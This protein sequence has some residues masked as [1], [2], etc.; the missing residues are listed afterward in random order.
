ME[1]IASS[2]AH[3]VGQGGP[4]TRRI[5]AW[6]AYYLGANPVGAFFT[7][8]AGLGK[9]A[10]MRADAAAATLAIRARAEREGAFPHA[11]EFY[12]SAGELR[13]AGEAW[14][15]F[16]GH[17]MGP[18]SSFIYLDE[19]HE[20]F[21]GSTV[22][23]GKIVSLIKG[24]SDP[25]RGTIREVSFGDEGAVIRHASTVAFVCG[26]NFP[27]KLK[28]AEAI[29]SRLG[30]IELEQYSDE[31][32][33][34]IAAII[35][36]AAGLR[37]DDGTLST[38]AR[39]GRGTARPVQK[40]VEALAREALLL[41]KHSVNKADVVRVMLELELYPIGL[42]RNEVAILVQ[43]CKGYVSKTT[44]AM[45]YNVEAKQIAESAAFLALKGMV[46]IKGATL[47]TT[48]EGRNYLEA[49]AK[50]KFRVPA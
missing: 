42:T 48:Q 2:F 30:R 39:C 14:S 28:D 44:L 43:G 37:V 36:K 13:R 6:Q 35:A 34:A 1:K 26:T 25:E 7:G 8:A 11:P 12:A 47:A 18:G 49:L 32:L 19:M 33:C 45:V 4:I 41:N 23:T 3:L 22:Q 29:L 5:K 27:S 40:I 38:I 9:T 50:C 21:A 10:L 46:T 24:L 15:K 16:I 31:E 17:A 20:L